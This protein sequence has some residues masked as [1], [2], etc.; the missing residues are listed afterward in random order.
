MAVK[1]ESS[2]LKVLG[3]EFEKPYFGK[4]KAFLTEQKNRGETVYPRNSDIFNAFE[5]CPFDEVKVA[6][7]G[8]DP[9]HGAQQAHG[10]SFSVQD[11]IKPPP[12]L[13]NI[14]K[15]L[16]NEYPDFK[17]PKSGN[18]SAWAKQGVLLLNATLTVGAGKPGSHQ[19]QGWEVF[20]D[21]VIRKVSELKE[22]VVFILW[23]NYA[24]QKKALIDASKHLIIESAHPSP[25]SAH[26]G[27]FGSKPFSRANAYLIQNK[28][29]TINWRLSE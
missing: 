17:E 24:R 20:T 29:A 12:S 9:Y 27:F 7:L 26:S 23:G 4:L 2:W 18:L 5:L 6:I 15:E 14:F 22:H 11:G 8:Q 13:R 1:L 19:N 16:A 28:K 3:A 25:F 10:L 21:E